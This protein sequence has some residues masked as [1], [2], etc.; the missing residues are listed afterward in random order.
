MEELLYV[1][2]AI[3]ITGKYYLTG[4]ALLNMVFILWI[5]ILYSSREKK[6]E[7]I[8]KDQHKIDHDSTR[9]KHNDIVP[10]KLNLIS[11]INEIENQNRKLEAEN[12]KLESEITSLKFQI[13]GFQQG[14]EEDSK[15]IDENNAE[16]EKLRNELD[17]KNHIE[18]VR[19]TG[20]IKASDLLP[21]EVSIDLAFG[22]CEVI[23]EIGYLEKAKSLSHQTPY[24]IED[25]YGKFVF[26]INNKNN[27]A[28]ANALNF[29]NVYI[30][31]FCEPENIYNP[32][33]HK[34]F[35]GDQNSKGILEKEGDKFRVVE[36]LKIRFLEG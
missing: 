16:L 33:I 15:R 14:S 21:T 28:I 22:K 12:K 6:Q 23:D 34:T 9:R 2:L 30:R 31:A 11:K 27:E 18:I 19:E 5:L 7:K 10:E 36:K 3:K 20:G 25:N 17:K 1:N 35:V 24:Y 29:Y 32:S 8:M 26:Y 4:S 13:E